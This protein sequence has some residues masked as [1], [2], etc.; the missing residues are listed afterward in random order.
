VGAVGAHDAFET[1]EAPVLAAPGRF[2]WVTLELHGTGR[3]SPRVRSLRAEHPSHDLL[4]R[5]P[6]TFS[7]D[8]R[9]AA[10]LRRYLSLFD[11]ALGELES[12]AD[13]RAILLD[14][15]AAP[16]EVLPWLASFLGL[17]LDERWPLPARRQ[18]IAETPQLWRARGT[19]AGLSRFLELYLGRAPVIVEHYRLRGLGGALLTDEQ[20]SLFAGAVVGANL[21]VGGAV[22]RP[23]DEPLS[24]DAAS[25]FETHAHRFTVLVPGVL[26]VNGMDVVRDVLEAHRPAHT[27]VEI[28]TVASGM[29]VGIGLH[30][31]LLAA[32]G[33]TGGFRTLQLGASRVGRDGIVGRPAAGAVLGVDSLRD[34]MRVG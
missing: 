5:L 15:H 23:G 14:P 2:L 33:R 3:A 17:A 12:R 21:R 7:R 24:G 30:V 16:E 29:R 31:G 25:A 18:L 8:E 10:F 28:C 26:D 34:G 11:G 1:Y 22:G 13:A 9:I 6:K 4:R 27:V 19:V 20:S 32:I